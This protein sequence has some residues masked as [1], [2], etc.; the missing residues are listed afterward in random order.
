MTYEIVP[1]DVVLRNQSC[2]GWKKTSSNI[3]E[4]TKCN[5]GY[6]MSASYCAAC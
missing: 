1:N 3:C 4:C 5:I 2:L 6:V